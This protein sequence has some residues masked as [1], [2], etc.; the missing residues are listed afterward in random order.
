VAAAASA[1]AGISVAGAPSSEQA[2]RTHHCGGEERWAVKTLSDPAADTSVNY[3]PRKTSVR[4]LRAKVPPIKPTLGPPRMAPVETRT[5]RLEGVALVEARHVAKKKANGKFED[6]D[7][8]VVIKDGKGRTMIVEF[9]D[10]DCRGAA[11]SKKR[12]RMREAREAFVEA[13]GSVPKSSFAEFEESWADI[14]GVG[15][16]DE[17][18]GQRGVAETNG[19]ELHPVLRFKALSCSR[20]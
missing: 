18:H 5:W 2:A 17:I 4:T 16:F 1:V 11:Q 14:E 20:A 9:P 10:P 7:I 6:M 19:I 12:E 3:T 15:F 8:H 13:C